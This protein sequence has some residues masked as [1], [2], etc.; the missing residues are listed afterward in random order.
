MKLKFKDMGECLKYYFP[1]L[2][3]TEDEKQNIEK[4]LF[5]KLT[6]QQKTGD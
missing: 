5:E 3:F 4:L 2:E 6:E 1:D